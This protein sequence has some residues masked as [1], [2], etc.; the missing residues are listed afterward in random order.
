MSQ[1]LSEHYAEKSKRVQQKLENFRRVASEN[2]IFDNKEWAFVER[3]RL[4][5]MRNMILTIRNIHVCYE[6]KSPTK[7]GHPF[8][9]GITLH[10]IHLT[11]VIYS[12]FYNS[13]K[14]LRPLNLITEIWI[15]LK[16]KQHHYERSTLIFNIQIPKM[17][18]HVDAE[19][20]SDILDFV[21]FQNYTKSYGIVIIII[22]LFILASS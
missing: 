14:I 13:L 8:S 10:Y 20:I 15:T 1:D 3:M 11:V 16:P 7:L 4:Q 5:V 2:A 19:Q 21:K 22:Y 17:N 6:M 18:F 12:I 9:F